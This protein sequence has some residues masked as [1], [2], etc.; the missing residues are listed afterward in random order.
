MVMLFVFG[1]VIIGREIP[2]AFSLD[3]GSAAVGSCVLLDVVGVF[4]SEVFKFVGMFSLG[5]GIQHLSTVDDTSLSLSS[6][7]D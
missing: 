6:L 2:S 5:G 7:I 1:S 4:S 3:R